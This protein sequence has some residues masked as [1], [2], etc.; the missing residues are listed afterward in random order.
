MTKKIIKKDKS[1]NQT[2][3]SRIVIKNLPKFITEDEIRDIFIKKGYITD[4]NMIRDV[5]GN[6]RRVAFV[7]YRK[8]DEAAD[9]LKW[10]NNSLVKNHKISVEFAVNSSKTIKNE[11][12]LRKVE[13]HRKFYVKNL[14]NLNINEIKDDLN[15][16]HYLLKEED[17]GISIYFEHAKDAVDF[18]KNRKVICGRRIEVSLY[19]EDQKKKQEDHFNTLF[20]NFNMVA[21]NTAEI[22]CKN[23]SE[24]IDVKDKSLGVKMTI[25]EANL[26]EKTKKF[27]MQNEIDLTREIA[28]DKNTLIIRCSDILNALSNIKFKHKAEI[29]PSRTLAICYFENRK[30]AEIIQKKL[31][32]KKQGEEIIYAEYAP[33]KN[34]NKAIEDKSDRNE[35]VTKS[36]KKSKANTLC[37]KNLP[38]QATKDEL[39]ELFGT[40]C[41]VVDIRI[42]QKENGQ[43]RG[44]AFVT[45]ENN[46][47]VDKIMEIFG[48]SGHL[49][50]RKLIIQKAEK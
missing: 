50:G 15:Y 32:F 48:T 39:K 24:F 38:F 19:D 3:C 17:K 34:I 26:I 7:G 36:T 5:N 40:F 44:F 42:P 18:Y 25:L 33:Q 20:F 2:K 13:Y 8:I 30:E 46:N 4:I 9:A 21:K 16:T 22:E 28:L 14:Q 27:L 23:I 47:A 41:K 6:F 43:S 49:Y 31:N 45:L 11:N 37:I 12:I 35:N 1:D 10:F 29:S